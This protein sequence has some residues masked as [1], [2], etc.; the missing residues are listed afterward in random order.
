MNT[1]IAAGVFLLALVTN[2]LSFV[3]IKNIEEGPTPA[4]EQYPVLDQDSSAY[5]ALAE[6]L[7]EYSVYSDREDLTLN[8]HWPIGYPLFLA[9]TKVLSGN[10]YL[11][12]FIQILAS[13]GAAVLVYWMALALL[14]RYLA[15]IP[16]LVLVLDPYLLFFNG[17]IRSD[18][19]FT[20]LLIAV[21]YLLF[22]RT[23]P[24]PRWQVFSIGAVLG[25][26][27]LM[28]PIGQFLVICLPVAYALYASLPW[29][30][31]LIAGGLFAAGFA[32]I[33][34]PWATR[35]YQAFGTFELSHIAQFDL[36]YYNTQ[37]YLFYQE[38]RKERPQPVLMTSAPIY[39]PAAK[40]TMVRVEDRIASDLAAATPEGENP[41]D[42]YGT[43]ALGYILPNPFHYTYFHLVNTL[44][45]F[46]EG[47]M[48]HHGIE[49]RSLQLRNGIEVPTVSLFFTAQTVLDGGTS[50]K[51]RLRAAWTLAIPLLDVLWRIGLTLLAVIGVVAAPRPIRVQ[52]Y[53]LA[54][55]V[56]Y[57]AV[58][59]GPISTTARMHIP[60][61][62]YLILL[63]TAGLAFCIPLAVRL[64]KKKWEFVRFVTVGVAA[65]GTDLLLLYLLTEYAGLHYLVSASI[66]LVVAYSISFVL[67]KFWTFKDRGME[68]IRVQ[69]AGHTLFALC[70]IGLNAVLLWF[71]V[72]QLFVWYIAAQVIAAGVIALE[73]FVVYK[74]VIF[75]AQSLYSILSRGKRGG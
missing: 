25:V 72:E 46:L 14:P 40:E 22:F 70:N 24:Y 51:D 19:L 12:A 58:L 43:V 21:I 65:T 10:F 73:S 67:Q 62:P 61:E 7:I 27:V 17:A 49:T 36:L 2:T 28:R 56:L 5:V 37:S 33:C 11:A 26:A 35:N 16:P 66:A 60:T 75:G 52:I 4:P 53:L 39:T 31:T 18:S 59:T 64:W 6:N 13:A 68:R 32:L 44:P 47:N 9:T 38:L 42:Y 29:R 63:A 3:Y 8:R 48:R 34:V 15:L 23:P 30:R 50:L 54:S 69:A 1:R 41:E 55:L 20:S 45:F 57:F 71:L 74:K